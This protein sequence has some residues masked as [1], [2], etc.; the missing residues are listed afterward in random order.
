MARRAASW[1]ACSA[2]SWARTSARAVASM[3]LR[4][5]S[6]RAMAASWPARRSRRARVSAWVAASSV[7]L[8]RTLPVA[9]P[10]LARAR[11][12]RSSTWPATPGGHGQLVD[13]AGGQQQL[14]GG[15]GPAG[16]QV[17]DVAGVLGP[18]VLQ[19]QLGA[20]QLL[21][22]AVGGLDEPVQAGLGGAVGLGKGLHPVVQLVDLALEA[23][24][25]GPGRG[26]GLRARGLGSGQGLR[27]R[28]LG[29]GQGGRGRHGGERGQGE[30]DHRG[31]R[32]APPGAEQVHGTVVDLRE[33]HLDGRVGLSLWGSNRQGAA[34]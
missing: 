7:T 25:L 29:S 24:R 10:T 5:A 34:T 14:E 33:P 27:A 8:A 1:R 31:S 17:A 30:R 13:V 16:V 11:T 4:S 15:Q 12:S 26:Q 3:A 19:G 23:G 32:P 6:S 9:S 2:R 22:V 20:L 21:L 18:G 28:G